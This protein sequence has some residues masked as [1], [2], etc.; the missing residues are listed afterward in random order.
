V[1]L[2]SGE[3]IAAP[4]IVSAIGARNT[5]A[6]LPRGTAPIWRQAV[7]SLDSGLSY[8]SL[9]VGFRGDI[10]R[11]GAT[12]ANVWVY[13]RDDVGQVWERPAD[14][15]APAMFVSFPSLKDSAHADPEHHTAEV[16]VIPAAVGC[17]ASRRC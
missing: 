12:P 13:E 17:P 14:E 15:E 11:Y 1:R 8:V 9:Y 3:L 7:E 4:V 2:A 6:A 10:R 5:A 16:T